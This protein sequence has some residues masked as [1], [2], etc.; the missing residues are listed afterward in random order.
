MFNVHITERR[1]TNPGALSFCLVEAWGATRRV[2]KSC[3]VIPEIFGGRSIMS[4]ETR[5]RKPFL[6]QAVLVLRRASD[7]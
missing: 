1:L 6:E 4:V 5:S 7:G 3:I 2:F